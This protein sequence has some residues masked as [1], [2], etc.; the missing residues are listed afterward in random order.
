ML[1]NTMAEYQCR[2]RGHRVEGGPFRVSCPECGGILEP[3]E[4]P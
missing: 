4:G 1:C 2:N 3:A